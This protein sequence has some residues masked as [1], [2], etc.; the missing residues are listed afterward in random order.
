[1]VS[2]VP[3]NMASY[4]RISDLKIISV[5]N[6]IEVY[7]NPAAFSTEGMNGQDFPSLGQY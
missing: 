5:K 4:C 1:M 7:R 2:P 6:S 3:E